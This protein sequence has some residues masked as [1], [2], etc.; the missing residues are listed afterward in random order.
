MKKD[1]SKRLKKLHGCKS[2]FETGMRKHKNIINS[3][4]TFYKSSLKSC[5]FFI[6]GCK[7]SLHPFSK[8]SEFYRVDSRIRLSY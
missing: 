8:I 4:C 3:F 2:G 6:K 7:V 1:M 5:S